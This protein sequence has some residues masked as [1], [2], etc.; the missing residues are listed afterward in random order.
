MDSS[1]VLALL[2]TLFLALCSALAFVL[3]YL[4]GPWQ[5]AGGLLQA[6]GV[7]GP[8][9]AHAHGAKSASATHRAP[10]AA[11]SHAHAHADMSVGALAHA[12][13]PAAQTAPPAPSPAQPALTADLALRGRKAKKRGG[14]VHVTVGAGGGGAG[15]GG[16]SAGGGRSSRAASTHAP[17]VYPLDFL[18]AAPPVIVCL[19][20]I[21][22]RVHHIDK[23]LNSIKTQNYP[24]AQMM[25][26]IPEESRREH[27]KYRSDTRPR[28][29]S[30]SNMREESVQR[31]TRVAL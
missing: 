15:V 11:S 16:V 2:L 27:T 21:P 23:C 6:G 8:H 7:N 20:T 29:P 22:S 1:S 10:T 13:G 25:L 28:R 12:L 19:T 30:T 9:H 4:R 3:L 18:S 5:S 14:R 24:I 31:V 26:A 17:Y